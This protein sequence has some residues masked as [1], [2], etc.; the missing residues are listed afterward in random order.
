[1]PPKSRPTEPKKPAATKR[2]RAKPPS[3]AS[4]AKDTEVVAFIEALDHPLRDEVA[5]VREAILAVDPSIGEGIKWNAPSFRTTEFFATFHLR[6]RDTLQLVL[7]LGAKKR[8]TIEPLAIDDPDGL[9]KWLAKDR[10]LVT[11]GTVD[12]IPRRIAELQAIVRSWI[13]YV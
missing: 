11:L 8:A 4:Q 3:R 10:A 9:L 13:R 2:S 6:S 7:H 5:R 1:M 12:E